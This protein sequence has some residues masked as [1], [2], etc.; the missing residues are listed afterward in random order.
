MSVT[1]DQFISEEE[2]LLLFIIDLNQHHLEAIMGMIKIVLQFQ[3]KICLRS[4]DPL[5]GRYVYDVPTGEERKLDL[6][7]TKWSKKFEYLD[8]NCKCE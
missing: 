4:S 1:Q 2:H 6:A 8:R 3:L 5:K 7:L